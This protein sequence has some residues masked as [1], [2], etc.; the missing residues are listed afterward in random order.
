MKLDLEMLAIIR[1]ADGDICKLKFKGTLFFL[2]K[3]TLYK[4]TEPRFLLENN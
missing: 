2:Y 1:A 4:N 3:N